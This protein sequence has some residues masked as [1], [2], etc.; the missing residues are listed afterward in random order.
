MLIKKLFGEKNHSNIIPISKK[1]SYMKK[2]FQEIIENTLKRNNYIL[3]YP[4]EEMWFNYRKPRTLKPGA[5]Y[6]AA[7]NNVPIISCFVEIIDT[8][9]TDNSE[10]YKVKYVLHILPPI[11]P[12]HNKTAKENSIKMMEIDYKQKKDAYE[13]AYK[14]KLDYSFNRGDIAGWKQAY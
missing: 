1:I 6:Y 10:F 12:E 8:N 14:Q 4:E 2:E 13:S 11:Y 3:I 5:Y 9:K 7:K